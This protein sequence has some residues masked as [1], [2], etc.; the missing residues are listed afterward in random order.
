MNEIERWEKTKSRFKLGDILTGKI[1]DK[2]PFGIILELVDGQWGLILAPM[3]G[4]SPPE[5]DLLWDRLSIGEE[6]TGIA[7]YF[8]D[9]AMN[10]KMSRRSEDYRLYGKIAD[11]DNP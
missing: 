9:H 2:K 5:S 8:D 3:M 1:I 7:V 6:I 4:D 10:V 11:K